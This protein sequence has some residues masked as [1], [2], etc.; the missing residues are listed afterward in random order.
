M[1]YYENID[2][3]LFFLRCSIDLKKNFQGEKLTK[4][5]IKKKNLF[6]LVYLAN[7]LCKVKST[8]WLNY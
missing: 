7:K 5:F 6:T 8:F 2:V 3:T 1:I 4:S